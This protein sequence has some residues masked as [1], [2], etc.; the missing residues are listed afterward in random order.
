MVCISSNK[1]YSFSRYVR[2]VYIICANSDGTFEAPPG[3]DNSVESAKQRIAFNARILQTFTAEHLFIHGFRRKTFRL[4]ED[5]DG[6]VKVNVFHSKLE[7]NKA[8][9]MSGNELYEYFH[10]GRFPYT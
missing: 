5:D 7:L 9:C 2:P 3:E 1:M 8:L 10:E 4:E 6:N